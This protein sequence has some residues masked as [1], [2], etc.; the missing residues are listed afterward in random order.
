MIRLPLLPRWLVPACAGL[1]LT[2]FHVPLVAETAPRLSADSLHSLLA[3]ALEAFSE[4]DFATAADRFQ[5]LEND[6][7]AEPEFDDPDF[8]RRMWPLRGHA[9]LAAGL[10]SA[11]VES[12]SQFVDA[13]PDD[14]Q[15]PEALSALAT[16]LHRIGQS[17]K[18]V[19]RLLEF[20]ER[21][22][23]RPETYLAK[24]RRAEI[25]FELGETGDAIGLLE[26]LSSSEAPAIL[27]QQAR[28]RASRQALARDEVSISAALLLDYPWNT[29]SIA[30][31]IALAFAALELGDRLME[32]E[33]FGRAVRA[34]RLVPPRAQ[35]LAWQEEQIETL[36]EK[37]SGE[38]KPSE[39][40]W[41]DYYRRLL[42]TMVQRAS[43]LQEGEDYTPSLLLRR[44]QAFLVV[45]R[46]YE[47][48]LLF[49]QLAL[50]ETLPASTRQEAHY[51]WVLA[52]DGLELWE[53]ALAIARNFLARYPQA[54]LAPQALYLIAQAHQEQRRYP[55][56]AEILADLGDRFPDH[57]LAQRWRFTLGFNKSTQEEF[58]RARLHFRQA[59]EE[60]PKTQL[61]AKAELWHAL[62]FFFERDYEAALK[63]F[64][65]LAERYSNHPLS[66][67]ILY[68]RASTLYAMRDY[69]TAEKEAASFVDRFQGHPRHGEALVLLGDIRMGAGALESAMAAFQQI[70]P[71]A[72]SLFLYG[73]FQQGKILRAR[74]DHA[75][76]VDLFS[77]YAERP[78]PADKPRLSEALYWIG[79]AHTQRG[80][81]EEAIPLFHTALTE[82][83]NDPG[84]AEIGSIL[85]LLEKLHP[86]PDTETEFSEWIER[87]RS[88]A[89]ASAAMTYFSR[90][91]LHLASSARQRGRNH[92]ADNFLFEIAN[93]IPKERL[94]PDALGNIGHMMA[95]KDLQS[96]EPLFD[97]LLKEYPDAPER[98]FAYH[99]LAQRHYDHSRFSKAL[100]W[101]RRFENETPTHPLAP[102]VMLLGGKTLLALDKPEVAADRF[103]EILGLRHM[104]GRPHARALVGLAETALARDEPEKAIAY[105]QRVYTMHRAQNDLTAE[106]YYRSS[107]LFRKLDDPAAAH[108]TLSE[109]LSLEDLSDSPYFPKARDLKATLTPEIAALNE[110]PSE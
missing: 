85:E 61:T 82:H 30:E 56:A 58:S 76:M 47:A 101:I 102:D 24:L 93:L 97:H 77:E 7:A 2:A 67:E 109:M 23:G 33:K 6:F 45:E 15:H 63:E 79:W 100:T 43:D 1:A 25:L 50:D 12:L 53:D 88:Q 17:E 71:E 83:A 38:S 55:E 40:F 22:P 70:D 106:A 72:G 84:A 95:K 14:P 32:A 92:Q 105:Y 75:G 78:D 21:Y 18:A 26:A 60:F 52:A 20:A 80:Q 90:L 104:R 41:A 42:D 9:E 86:L 99:G 39:R 59:V 54:P 19:R 37:V 46:N 48:W 66:G 89:L 91:N 94:G 62:S 87:K 81:P 57:P 35:L 51:R 96:A 107:H 68:R 69:E 49:E 5:R 11:A 28:L 34:Y 8:L 44:G 65:R 73:L 16:G 10:P 3:E 110:S 98:A 29:E 4:Q 36:Q 74:K 31:I 13:H 108:R 64:N 103:E 27:R